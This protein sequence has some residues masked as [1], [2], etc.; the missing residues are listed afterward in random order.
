MSMFGLSRRDFLGESQSDTNKSRNGANLIHTVSDWRR[1]SIP[2]SKQASSEERGKTI[3]LISALCSILM[4]YA[5]YGNLDTF[6]ASRCS[7][8]SDLP[9]APE[10]DDRPM[11]ADERKKLFK[12]R[13]SGGKKGS[14]PSPGGDGSAA[15]RG[16]VRGVLLLNREEVESLF[17]DVVE[18]LAFLVGRPKLDRPKT[19]LM[20]IVAIAF[21]GDPASGSEM[22]KCAVAPVRW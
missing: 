22:P 14:Q 15:P 7:S 21:E 2:F 10:D 8:A 17:G 13:M 18:G 19:L 6:I 1:L 3:W 12:R 5:N 16:D 20:V 9:L 4:M 11:T